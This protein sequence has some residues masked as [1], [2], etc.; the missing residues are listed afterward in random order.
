MDLVTFTEEILNRE[1]HFLC[2]EL[3][4]FINEILTPE[5]VMQNSN[6]PYCVTSLQLRKAENLD[7]SREW[8]THIRL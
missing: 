1:P 3:F 8:Y 5:K 2:S 6:L 4:Q 7:M